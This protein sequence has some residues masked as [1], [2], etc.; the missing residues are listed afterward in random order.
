[1]IVSDATCA[2]EIKTRS[3]IAKAAYIKKKTLN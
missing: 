2:C 3:V 1:M